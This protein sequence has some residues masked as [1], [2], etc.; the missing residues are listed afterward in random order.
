MYGYLIRVIFF[1]EELEIGG[2]CFECRVL[3]FM[4]LILDFVS[5]PLNE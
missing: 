3:D 4:S 5:R 2:R 1:G